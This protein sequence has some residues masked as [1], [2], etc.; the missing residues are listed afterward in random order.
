MFYIADIEGEIHVRLLTNYLTGNLIRLNEIQYST[1]FGFIGDHIFQSWRKL[2][3][4]TV[5]FDMSMTELFRKHPIEYVF[6][7]RDRTAF[8]QGAASE[9]LDYHIGKGSGYGNKPS[10]MQRQFDK[11][12]VLIWRFCEAPKWNEILNINRV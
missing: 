10:N 8:G 11:Q 5:R 7:F 3:G 12:L 1:L 4:S 2:D 9:V 6:L